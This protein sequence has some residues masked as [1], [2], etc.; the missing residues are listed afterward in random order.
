M[1][2][3]ILYNFLLFGFDL[4]IYKRWVSLRWYLSFDFYFPNYTTV[5]LFNGPLKYARTGALLIMVSWRKC[6][7]MISQSL[8]KMFSSEINSGN[9]VDVLTQC[10][11][12]PCLWDIQNVYSNKELKIRSARQNII[13]KQR[14]TTLL[15]C[16]VQPHYNFRNSLG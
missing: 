1:S 4:K 3:L 11:T 6:N 12:N 5:T 15:T 7:G 10:C 13:N 14:T 8:E 2:L 9:L 16:L